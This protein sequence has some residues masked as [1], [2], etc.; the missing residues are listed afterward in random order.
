M[1]TRPRS[2]VLPVAHAGCPSFTGAAGVPTDASSSA[3]GSF[4]VRRYGN[5]LAR[6]PSSSPRAVS[7]QAHAPGPR[8]DPDRRG[9]ARV[10]PDPLDER[11]P[12]CVLRR[13]ATTLPSGRDDPRDAVGGRDH[14]PAPGLDGPQP[15]DREL[16]V[17]LVGVDERRVAGLHDERARRRCGP[18]PGSRRRRRRR[19]RSRRR[20][21]RRRWS[22]ARSRVPASMSRPTWRAGRSGGCR[23]SGGTGCTRRRHRVPLGVAVPCAGHRVPDDALVEHLVRAGVHDRADQDRHADRRAGCSDAGV[24]LRVAE[25]VDGGGVLRPDARSRAA[26]ARPPPRRGPARWSRRRGSG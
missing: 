15:G 16:L 12:G 17:D 23:D 7:G 18:G 6:R 26:A 9:D 3:R 10:E 22:A 19:S 1:T 8:P 11:R 24:G 13:S 25:R 14:H 21:G 5:L 2:W 4:G 20:P